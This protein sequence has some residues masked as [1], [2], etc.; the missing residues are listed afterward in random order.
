MTRTTKSTRI[1]AVLGAG[2]MVLA[3]GGSLV[4]RAAERGR[5]VSVRLL[6][7]GISYGRIRA[8]PDGSVDTSRVRGVDEDLRVK[9]F[10][11]EGSSFAIR[12]FV[13]GAFSKQ[14]RQYHLP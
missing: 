11:A 6:S 8:E 5:E 7:K 9:P 3:L 10:F 12:Q 14:P 13:V 1:A 4:L 2:A